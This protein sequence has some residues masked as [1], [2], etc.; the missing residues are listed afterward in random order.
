MQDIF[1]PHISIVR[2]VNLCFDE[3]YTPQPIIQGKNIM[4]SMDIASFV[5]LQMIV[6][7]SAYVQATIGFGLGMMVMAGIAVFQLLPLV[8]AANFATIVGLLN[9]VVALKGQYITV[10][11]FKQMPYFF[12]LIPTS[13]VGFF[14]LYGVGDNMDLYTIFYAVL[15]GMIV[16]GAIGVMVPPKQDAGQSPPWMF[17]SMFSAS[18][19]LGGL[20]GVPGAPIIYT[21][22]RQPWDVSLIRRVM[23]T[24]FG[25]IFVLRLLWAGYYDFPLAEL[26]L[27]LQCAPAIVLATLLGRRHQHRVNL[28][29]IRRAAFVVLLVSG[30]QILVRVVAYFMGA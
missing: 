19:V 17:Y 5:I 22:S 23:L 11:E 25:T 3:K 7:F 16:A 4:E 21:I 18:G 8:Y 30:V 26:L 1:S 12:V 10:R 13:I 29:I 24:S 27:V 9:V 2:G 20:F 14:L 28:Q 15:G 6:A